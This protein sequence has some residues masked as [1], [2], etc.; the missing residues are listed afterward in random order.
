MNHLTQSLT[1]MYAYYVGKNDD[2]EGF[3]SDLSISLLE[4]EDI[5]ALPEIIARDLA[6]LAAVDEDDE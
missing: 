1:E 3:L 5:D 2:L 4:M 6:T